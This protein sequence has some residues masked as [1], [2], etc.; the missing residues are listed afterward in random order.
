MISE[1]PVAPPPTPLL[2]AIDEGAAIADLDSAELE[3][4]ADEL[5]RYLL[6]SV[7]QSGG[8]FGAGL[9]VVELT[10]ALHHV[11]D[12]PHDR[13]VWDVGHQTYPH[14]ILTGRMRQMQSIRQAGGLAGFPKRSES[15]YD[16]FGVGHSSTSISAAMGMA[17]A[18]RQ[19]GIER[20][21]VAVIG[22]GAITGGMAFEALA[23]AGHERPNMLVVLNDNQMSIGH[24]TGGLAT[25]FAKIWATKTYLGMRERSK[26]FLEKFSFLWEWAKRT[27]EHMKGMVAPGTLFEELGFH[28]IGPLD[29]HDLPQLVRTLNNMMELDGPQFLHIRTVKGK[30]YLPAEE[31][32]VGY[33]AINKIEAKPKQPQPTVA[34][35]PRGPKYQA[36]FGQWLCDMA[37]Q[38]DRLVGITPAMCEGSGMVEFAAQYP[39]RYYDVAIAE[40]HA[41]TLAA[42]MACDGLKPVVAIY[43]TFLQRGYDQLIHDVALQ[44]LD[45]TFGI[46][47]AGLVGEDGPTHHGAFDLSYLRCIPNLVIGAPS[48]ENECRQLLYTAFQHPGP[49]AVRYPRGQGPGATIEETMAAVEIGRAVT[50]RRGSAVAILNFGTLLAAAREAAEAH[51]ATLLDMRWVKP[52]DEDAVLA[53]AETHR[54]I[55]TVEENAVAGGAGSAV[56]ELLAAHGVD[57]AV[58]NLGLP[59]SFIQH[60]AHSLLLQEAGL[61]AAGITDAIAQRCSDGQPLTAAAEF[62][63]RRTAANPGLQTP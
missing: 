40:Q 27:E 9:G 54:L 57:V 8:H 19:Q 28:Y 37:A 20:K 30:G 34:A 33:H 36:V 13:L 24:N 35:R 3:Q 26:R 48:D 12:T 45:V 49:A 60:G 62:P 56:N 39:E 25:Y 18:A 44:N 16:T 22:D 50:L 52:L 51:G 4:L 17:L 42:G 5:R 58:L 41:V 14:K 47:R 32:P 11:L 29:G 38:D 43:S 31:D 23:H 53:A 21:V 63:E 6:Y 55:V 61:D 2:Q 7:G 1:I 59:D 15:E 10:V 46:D